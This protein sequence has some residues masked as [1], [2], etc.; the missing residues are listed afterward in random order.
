[1]QR[2]ERI[3]IEVKPTMGQPIMGSIIWLHGLGADGH[4]FATLPNQLHL[5]SNIALRFIFPHAPV[6]PV[7]INGRLPTRAWYD[8]YSFNHLEQE[9]SEGILKIQQAIHILIDQEIASGIASEHIILAG[10]SQGGATALQ[11][12]LTYPKALGGII[13]LSTYLPLSN[14]L[15]SRSNAQHLH[16]LPV[17]LAH[18]KQDT[19]L[20]IAL[21][22]A[23]HEKLKQCGCWVEWHSYSM[24]HEVSQK[25]IDAIALWLIK[26]F[27]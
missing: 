6:I 26:R 1:M 7:T 24:G 11:A 22:R 5:P 9:D 8:I 2:L 21:G 13:A 14:Q 16:A 23:A 20:P 3:T 25:E 18:G 10:F 19:V 15:A 27:A 12:G 17:F 4:D